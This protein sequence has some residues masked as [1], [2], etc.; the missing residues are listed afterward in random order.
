M[1]EVGHE[2]SPHFAL[3]P[4]QEAVVGAAFALEPAS[5]HDYRLETISIEQNQVRVTYRGPGDA[6]YTL[7]CRHP[8]DDPDRERRTKSFTLQGDL[9]PALLDLVEASLRAREGEVRWRDLRNET[10]K[11]KR[12]P[13]SLR[14]AELLAFLRGVKPALRRSAADLE[15]ADQLVKTIELSGRAACRSR[16]EVRLGSRQWW[17]VYGASTMAEAMQL[18]RLDAAPWRVTKAARAHDNR[19]LGRRLGYPNCC[20]EGFV[21][22]DLRMG[23]WSRRWLG[24]TTHYRHLAAREAWSEQSRWELNP[25]L[26]GEGA[27]LISFEPCSYSCPA[28]LTV[29]RATFR[30][31]YEEDPF[32]AEE[33]ERRLRC[34]LAVDADGHITRLEYERGANQE[35]VRLRSASPVSETFG[36]TS[37]GAA[38]ASAAA[39]KRADIRPTP[40]SRLKAGATVVVEFGGPTDAS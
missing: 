16:R 30:A 9:P 10:R 39:A 4:D 38:T 40:P 20:V 27:S 23:G 5:T 29:A 13:Q 25:H 12:G 15:R 3:P 19:E 24:V 21:S 2:T 7:V 31:L 14:D 17:V 33:L 8:E 6:L 34:T 1:A 36:Q 28:A 22:R 37:S 18:R 26:M 11:K 32:A 35:I